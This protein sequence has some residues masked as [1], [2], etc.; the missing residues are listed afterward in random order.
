MPEP[1][2]R[3]SGTSREIYMETK[4]CFKCGSTNWIYIGGPSGFYYKCKNCD[5]VG[6]RSELKTWG[7]RREMQKVRGMLQICSP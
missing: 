4:V 5:R 7:E 3:E 2:V 1:R 6:S